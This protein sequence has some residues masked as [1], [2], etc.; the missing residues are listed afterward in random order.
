MASRTEVYIDTSAFI[1]ALDRSDTYHRTYA[2]LLAEPPPLVTSSLVIT[3]G[4]GW[5]LR[6]FDPRKAIQFL[7]FIRELTPLTVL[8]F[9]SGDL[10]KLSSL[11]QKFGD[12]SVT[13]AD[14]HG[15]VIMRERRIL[16][17]WS[18]DRHLALRGTRLIM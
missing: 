7:V 1:A 14:L 13:L 8:P 18:T 9:G 17:C 6:R 2:R 12:Q 15:L 4:H 5:F 16:D 11:L 10:G 3:E